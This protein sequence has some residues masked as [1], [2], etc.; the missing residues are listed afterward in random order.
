LKEDELKL[1]VRDGILDK[2]Y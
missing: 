2:Y 1:L